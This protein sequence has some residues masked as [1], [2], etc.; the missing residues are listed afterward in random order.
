VN[1]TLI[2]YLIFKLGNRFWHQI[3]LRSDS[4][5]S[6]LWFNR[7]VVEQHMN[8]PRDFVVGLWHRHVTCNVFCPQLITCPRGL[9]LGDHTGSALCSN[10]FVVRQHLCW[11]HDFVWWCGIRL[12]FRFS[13]SNILKSAHLFCLR[14]QFKSYCLWP[15][16]LS[17]FKRACPS[18]LR[19]KPRFNK[20][21]SQKKLSLTPSMV[22][23][24]HFIS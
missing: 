22:Y 2:D 1:I 7:L 4:T 19:M 8:L 10:W 24:C 20:L 16:T 12:L 5:F 18:F 15:S 21:S 23:L 6:T 9:R 11:A 3:L 14:R 17:R 13:L